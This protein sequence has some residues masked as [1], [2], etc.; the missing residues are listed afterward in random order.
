MG[1]SQT[2]GEEHMTEFNDFEVLLMIVFAAVV[3]DLA[4]WG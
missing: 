4:F 3:L 1:R 2:Q